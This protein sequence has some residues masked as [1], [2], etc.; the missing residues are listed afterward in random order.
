M[1]AASEAMIRA[2]GGTFRISIGPFERP[3]TA[4]TVTRSAIHGRSREWSHERGVMGPGHPVMR[5]PDHRG[6]RRSQ[7]RGDQE[8]GSDQRDCG[9]FVCV[10]RA[11]ETSYE[12]G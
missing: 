11:K 8:A 2:A 12:V 7:Y 1:V 10:L 5:G 9:P 3:D 6:G 4:G